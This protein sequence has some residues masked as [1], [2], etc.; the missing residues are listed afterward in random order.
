[1]AIKT[2]INDI[3]AQIEK[4]RERKKI[5]IVKSAERYARAATKAG[6]AEMEVTD[7]EVDQIFT[8][9][10]ARFHQKRKKA[11]QGKRDATNRQG[12]TSNGATAEIPDDR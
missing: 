5:L 4:L 9:I 10:A 2:S 11:D 7:D 3:D 12:D 8:E 6:L 1:M